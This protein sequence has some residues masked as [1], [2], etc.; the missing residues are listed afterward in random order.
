MK[1]YSVQGE[2]HLGETIIFNLGLKSEGITSLPSPLSTRER[3][4]IPVVIEIML[5]AGAFVYP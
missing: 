1:M 5:Q 4:L 2:M 3:G